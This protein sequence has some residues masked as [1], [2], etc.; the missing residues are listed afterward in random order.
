MA[1]PKRKLGKARVRTRRSH[2][3]IPL[4]SLAKCGRC[5]TTIK[6][7]TVCGSCGH[8]RGNMIVNMDEDAS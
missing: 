2:H 6:P 4:A 5:G 1:V 8:Y 3:A 7:H